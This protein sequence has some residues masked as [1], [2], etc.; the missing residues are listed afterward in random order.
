MRSLVDFF[1]GA[2]AI[3]QIIPKFN[4]KPFKISSPE[5]VAGESKTSTSFPGI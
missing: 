2:I 1:E 4:T 5:T 3:Y